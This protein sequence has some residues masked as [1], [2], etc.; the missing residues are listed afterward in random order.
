[1]NY[2][3]ALVLLSNALHLLLNE[4]SL[5]KRLFT[6]FEALYQKHKR[7]IVHHLRIALTQQVNRSKFN[8][9]VVYQQHVI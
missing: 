7:H 6:P 9:N 4:R 5:L 8:P 2:V 1:M 3:L